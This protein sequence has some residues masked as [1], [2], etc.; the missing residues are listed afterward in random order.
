MAQ[1]SEVAAFAPVEPEVVITRV[2]DAPREVVFEAWINPQH[3][4]QWFGPKVFTN[5]VSEVD[6]RV[7]GKWKVVMRSP[8]G[9]EYPTVG[10]YRE[11]VKPER[12]VFTNN[13]LDKDGSK[14]LEGLTTVTFEDFDGKTKI[15]LVTRMKG[16]KPGTEHMLAGMDAGWSQSFDK[17]Q[18]MVE[19]K[20][21]VV[22]R[23]SE[24]ELLFTRTFDAPREL[25]F[26]AWTDPKHIEHWWGPIGFRTESIAMDVRPGGEWTLVMH[27]PDGTDYNNRIVYI[28]VVRP[29]RLVYKH[30]ELFQSTVTFE[31]LGGKTRLNMRMLFES[32][33][34]RNE[35][36]SKYHADEGGVQTLGRLGEY[37][38][39][40]A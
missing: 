19:N 4:A 16:L 5:P 40:L 32:E 21:A 30:G 31:D 37:L 23:P 22:A 35:T 8:D 3:L 28:E 17:L 14:L 34:A 33:A 1:R 2:F 6:A 24:R 9:T 39:S 29:E 20:R 10:V 38:A 7:G 18:V 15:T 26:D 36:I 12:L 27:G 13:A 25:V 11:F